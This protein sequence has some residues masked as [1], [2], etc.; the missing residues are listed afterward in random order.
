MY[1]F[2]FSHDPNGKTYWRV[3]WLDGFYNELYVFL[4][5]EIKYLNIYIIIN[6]FINVISYSSFETQIATISSFMS[7]L[8][9]RNVLASTRS[10]TLVL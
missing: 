8:S 1:S 7:P 10:F 3:L 9:A 2:Y 6:V 4:F 5:Y